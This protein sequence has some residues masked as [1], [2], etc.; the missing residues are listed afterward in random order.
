VVSIIR[1]K[2]EEDVVRQANDTIYG[3][4]SAVW[5]RDLTKAHRVARAIQAGTVWVNC[6]NQLP[7]ES[8]FGGY[9]QSGIGREL[10]IHAL[11][12]YTQ[13]KNVYVDLNEKPMN[14]YKS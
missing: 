14:W 7:N 11:E 13:V 8:P 1:F 2:G 6:Y 3:L 4:A 5:T 9:K 12:L 10:G